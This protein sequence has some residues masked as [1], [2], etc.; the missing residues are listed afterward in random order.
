MRKRTKRK[1]YALVNPIEH[2]IIGAAFPLQSKLDEL[3]MLELTCIER[4]CNGRATLKDWQS[5]S[6]LLAISE[7]MAKRGVGKDEVLP[8][9]TIVENELIEAAHRFEA[10]GR[11]VLTEAGL[12]ALRDL[13]EY[14]DLQR[15]SVTQREY[16][17][18]ILATYNRIKS[19]APDVKIIK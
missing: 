15:N 6:S 1:V 2:A 9:C 16:E 8:V 4:F 12:Q 11:M 18:M 10:T 13:Y 17:Q 7:V 14:H 3:R 5:M 19:Q